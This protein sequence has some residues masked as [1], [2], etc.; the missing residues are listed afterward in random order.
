MKF[1]H[2]LAVL[3]I[4]LLCAIAQFY[5]INKDRQHLNLLSKLPNGELY[6][7]N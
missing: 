5:T 6:A 2:L 4:I 7:N 1:I 3:G